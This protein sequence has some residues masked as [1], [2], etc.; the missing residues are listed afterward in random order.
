MVRHG[1]LLVVLLAVISLPSPA[2]E[3][4]SCAAWMESVRDYDLAFERVMK[5]EPDE[6]LRLVE[7][8]REPERRIAARETIG[9]KVAGLRDIDPPREL[10]AMH[11]KLLAYAEAVAHA[12]ENAGPTEPGTKVPVPRACIGRL[13][14]YYVALRDLMVKHD[15]RGGDLEALENQV[16]PRLEQLL[17]EPPP[18]RTTE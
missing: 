4:E 6:L 15:C 18:A 7:E 3:S 5:G 2:Q 13:L 17:V 11:G 8:A 16:I 12:V 1:A 14:D 9:K 10:A